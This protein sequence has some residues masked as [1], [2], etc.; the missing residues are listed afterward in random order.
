M[1][2][3]VQPFFW[4]AKTASPI[5]KV[6]N[7]TCKSEIMKSLKTGGST[8]TDSGNNDYHNKPDVSERFL[9]TYSSN[10][11]FPPPKPKPKPKEKE[12]IFNNEREGGCLCAA[13]LPPFFPWPLA[14]SLSLYFL[15]PHDFYVYGLLSA[16]VP[17]LPSHQPEQTHL[18]RMCSS[19]ESSSSKFWQC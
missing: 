10:S 17:F 15:L 13:T 9:S 14:S 11:F 12:M 4:V 1:I 19:L 3:L 16:A 7:C 2:R 6:H 8:T 5:M 18:I